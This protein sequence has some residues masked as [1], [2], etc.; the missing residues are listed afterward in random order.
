MASERGGD[1]NE[2]HEQGSCPRG[3]GDA[4][5]RGEVCGGVGRDVGG[6]G[7]EKGWCEGK[8]WMGRSGGGKGRGGYG[9]DEI[10]G[11]RKGGEGRGGGR[12]NGRVKRG[13]A[14][15]EAG[16]GEA[17]KGRAGDRT[18]ARAGGKR[19]RNGNK[20]GEWIEGTGALRAGRHCVDE[21]A[22][23]GGVQTP[24]GNPPL[25]FPAPPIMYISESR[26]GVR[27]QR[28]STRKRGLIY[29]GTS[30]ARP[31]VRVVTECV[32]A[33]EVFKP[34]RIPVLSRPIGVE[35]GPAKIIEC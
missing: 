1:K 15:K 27:G 18:G 29:W 30:Q 21:F 32:D 17:T 19:W 20:G 14:V 13:W 11:V 25:L 12:G 5:S 23:P 34:F 22:A 24:A 28:G 3:V 8:K 33:A 35:R 9:I 10:K 4:G 16:S 6:W 7:E 26:R 31:S 2:K